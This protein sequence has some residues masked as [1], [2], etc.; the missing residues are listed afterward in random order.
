METVIETMKEEHIKE[1]EDIL[2]Y[3][4]NNKN[5]LVQAFTRSSERGKN[6]DRDSE[7][8]EFIGDTVINYV[9]MQMF[10]R[11]FFNT[12]NYGLNSQYSEGELT[13]LKE[14]IVENKNLAAK[15]DDFGLDRFLIA[16]N[17]KK[18]PSSFKSDLLES[19][20]GAIAIDSHYQEMEI[21]EIVDYL[22]MP[23]AY[24][25]SLKFNYYLKLKEWCKIRCTSINDLKEYVEVIKLDNNIQYKTT[26]KFGKYEVSAIDNSKIDSLFETAR[27]AM[28]K[29]TD[30]KDEITIKDFLVGLD[31]NN[32][33]NYLQK[34]QK[35]G[36][37]SYLSKEYEK[38]ADGTWKAICMVDGMTTWYTD[39][40]K[41]NA[42]NICALICINSLIEPRFKIDESISAL[43]KKLNYKETV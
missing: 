7:I 3:T 10:T 33:W 23:R 12:D 9:I 35:L 4:F 20:V 6:N 43:L 31:Q 40:N 36:Y 2:G 29:I 22:L 39:S 5:L 42:S 34:L 41:K 17:E 26:L 38:N 24:I 32:G 19:I 8:L 15:I 14:L 11:Y 30:N 37:C 25:G 13:K 18:I 27:L 16:G 1:I 21:C 28:K